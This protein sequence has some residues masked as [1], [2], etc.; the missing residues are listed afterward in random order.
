MGVTP[1][2]T[3]N[4]PRPNISTMADEFGRDDLP[5]GR[6]DPAPEGWISP[7]LRYR[8]WAAARVA[9]GL[10]GEVRFPLTSLDAE[11]LE[12][13]PFV[14]WPRGAA[15]PPI[16]LKTLAV[17]KIHNVFHENSGY[18][19]RIWRVSVAPATPPSQARKRPP[20]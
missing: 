13:G 7:S 1:S 17:K 2:G 5:L 9:S 4:R 18:G 12:D 19:K 6:A 16:F 10:Y 3:C 15:W 20:Y 8:G 14:E 11:P